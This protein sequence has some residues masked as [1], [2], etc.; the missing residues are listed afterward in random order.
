MRNKIALKILGFTG[1][2]ARE[3]QKNI[4]FLNQ[5]PI[6]V[7][8]WLLGKSSPSF[9]SPPPPNIYSDFIRVLFESVVLVLSRKL[10][11]YI[12]TL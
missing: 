5:N 8:L 3:K 11:F 6:K 1:V 7:L 10:L 9:T 4:F 2:R 12:Y